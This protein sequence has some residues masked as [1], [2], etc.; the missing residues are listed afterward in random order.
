MYSFVLYVYW[1]V[2]ACIGDYRHKICLYW[3]VLVHIGMYSFVLYLYWHV[4]VCI[5]DSFT[6]DYCFESDAMGTVGKQQGTTCILT[7]FGKRNSAGGGPTFRV[8]ALTFCQLGLSADPQV[9]L[10]RWVPA[11]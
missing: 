2:L 4:F 3:Y 7:V 11:P 6:Y 9:S 1:H 5:G 8:S 10:S